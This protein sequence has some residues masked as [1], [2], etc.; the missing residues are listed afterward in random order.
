MLEE[1]TM[2]NPQSTASI[3]GHPLHPMLVPFPI[4]CFAGALVTDIA[5]SATDDAF[6]ARAS[7]YLLGAGLVM[8]ALAALAGLTDF[9]GERRI[10][11]L[12]A[13]WMHMVGNVVLVLIEAYNFYIRYEIAGPPA[14]PRHGLGLSVIAVLLMLFNGWQGWEMVYRHRVGVLDTADDPP[15]GATGETLSD[16]PPPHGRDWREDR[17]IH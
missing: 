6:F 11:R 12:N 4:A 16:T 14:L 7:F 3:A 17:R 13:A 9:L 8:A 15:G 5:F 10:R 1:Q 2:R